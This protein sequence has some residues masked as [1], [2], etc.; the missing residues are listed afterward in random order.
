MKGK[1]PSRERVQTDRRGFIKKMGG[2]T[3]SIAGGSLLGSIFLR[4][5][6]RVNAQD[7]AELSPY[8]YYVSGPLRPPGAVEED[9]FL[10]R[11]I[12]CFL[13]A[14]VC[15]PKAI[16]FVRSGMG[17]KANTPYIFPRERA[18]ILCMKC[19]QVCPTQALMPLKEDDIYEGKKK[20]DMGTAEIDKRLCI[21][22]LG[23]GKCEACYT[24]CPLKERAIVQE[25]MLRP[26][27]IPEGC[28]GCG[29]CEEICPVRAKA[30]RVR[31][32]GVKKEREV[33]P[34]GVLYF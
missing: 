27:V 16:R 15:P 10:K 8:A 2:I 31:L 6:G 5:L 33:L 17:L 26:R 13:C 12:Q 3:L 7:L 22:H 18:C 1:G 19:T 25:A 21:T 9:L 32:P 23:I 14:E 30:I 4:Y 20:V 29:L 11:C 28:V 24:I 34:P